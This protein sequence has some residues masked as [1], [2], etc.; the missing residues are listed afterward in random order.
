MAGIDD[1]CG[2]D[3]SFWSCPANANPHAVDMLLHRVLGSQCHNAGT[4]YAVDGSIQW[5]YHSDWKIVCLNNKI[6][7]FGKVILAKNT[8]FYL[9]M[10]CKMHKN[11]Y[12]L[13]TN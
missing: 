9:E 8:I 6:A 12:K 5:L 4:I 2:V 11:G 13:T 10:Y 1:I 7:D 3:S